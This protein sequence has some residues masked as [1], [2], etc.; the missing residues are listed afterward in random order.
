MLGYAAQLLYIDS[1]IAHEAF[2]CYSSFK[3]LQHQFFNWSIA[4]EM[5][6]F[7]SEKIYKKPKGVKFLAFYT[8]SYLD[9]EDFV[10]YSRVEPNTDSQRWH[11]KH[12]ILHHV[13]TE[14]SLSGEQSTRTKKDTGLLSAR[15]VILTN[16]IERWHS[17]RQLN[18]QKFI[19]LL[20]V[21]K[22]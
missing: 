13:H 14:F 20:W 2:L 21:F 16:M 8:S 3:E 9:T 7:S 6:V 22:K 4:D 18:L 12:K 19:M 1:L 15:K 5:T 11:E 17:L 10:H